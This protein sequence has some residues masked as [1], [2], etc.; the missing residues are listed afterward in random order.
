MP[1]GHVLI[2]LLSELAHTLHM[3]LARDKRSAVFAIGG[4]VFRAGL[5][6]GRPPEL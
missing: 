2:Q 1:V 5:E 4:C 6:W 3:R